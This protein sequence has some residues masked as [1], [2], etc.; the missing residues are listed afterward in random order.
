MRRRTAAL[1]LLFSL[2]AVLPSS[3]SQP[4]GPAAAEAQEAPTLRLTV[5]TELRR[6]MQDS[7][8]E[9]AWSDL[10]GHLTVEFVSGEALPMERVPVRLVAVGIR[11]GEIVGRA[12]TTPSLATAG[13][14]LPASS[15]AGAGWPPA[16]EW[17]P[18]GSWRP[19]GMGSPNA[20][21]APDAE[22]AAAQITLPS[23][24]GGLMI[25]AAPAADALV[26][27]F[28]TL[29]VV[30]TTWPTSGP[31]GGGGAAPDTTNVASPGDGAGS[32]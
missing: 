28:R 24:A 1:L 6:Q 25:F 13:E 21:V 9:L 19:D 30:V 3:A 8:A 31:A 11:D 27:R 18:A 7:P 14:S 26:Q 4:A 12:A 20:A 22:A 29:P 10:P 17:F 16:D 32:G 15:L 2:A 5:S 23:N